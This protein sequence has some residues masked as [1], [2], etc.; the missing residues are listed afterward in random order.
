MR[1]LFA[2]LIGCGFLVASFFFLSEIA[3]AGGW[4]SWLGG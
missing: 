4:F 2:L 3:I 1:D